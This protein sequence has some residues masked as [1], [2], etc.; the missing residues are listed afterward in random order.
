[1]NKQSQNLDTILVIDDASLVR[2]TIVGLCNRLGY[3][4]LDADGGVT[5]LN[6]LKNQLVDIVLV[7]LNMPIIDGYEIIRYMHEN[8][9]EVP[10][11]AIS[12]ESDVHRVVDAI[13]AGAWD[14]ILK[15]IYG[16]D[17]FSL[18]ITRALER[19]NLL[20]EN[21]LYKET[22]EVR[23][24]ERTKELEIT[25]DQLQDEV[26]IRKE[27]EEAVLELN[28][29]LE[30]RV[31]ERT[32]ELQHAYDNLNDAHKKMK[33]DEEAGKHMQFQLLPP[34]LE[35]FGKYEFSR[36]LLPSTILSGDFLD[37]FPLGEDSIICYMADISGHGVSSA[38]VTVIL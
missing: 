11:I 1:M 35:K 20:R 13:R 10:V 34:E 38:L 2:K 25:N 27:A 30:K 16:I 21:R 26:V 14:Y 4:T 17:M 7:D 37:Y 5:G 31:F 24:E 15:P 8:Q 18:V 23:I 29:D 6:V 22:L 36:I 9:P 33:D 32:R 28:R 12:G 19:A 3:F